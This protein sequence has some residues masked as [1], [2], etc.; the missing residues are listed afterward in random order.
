MIISKRSSCRKVG[1]VLVFQQGSAW[2]LPE[3]QYRVSILSGCD[4]PDYGPGHAGELRRGC[5]QVVA[6]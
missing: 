3:G 4:T 5:P 2:S 6:G 1:R